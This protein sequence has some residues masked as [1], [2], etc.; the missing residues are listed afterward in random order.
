M[1][2]CVFALVFTLAALGL[3]SAHDVHAALSEGAPEQRRAL[4]AAESTPPPS[5]LHAALQSP[6]G[7]S[8]SA[9]LS[10]PPWWGRSSSAIIGMALV[11]LVAVG[12]ALRGARGTADA[13]VVEGDVVNAT[14][15][16]SA[17]VF[18]MI[19]PCLRSAGPRMRRHSRTL[20]R[21]PSEIQGTNPMDVVHAHSPH[22]SSAPRPTSPPVGAGTASWGGAPRSMRTPSPTHG[23]TPKPSPFSPGLGAPVA[24]AALERSVTPARAAPSPQHVAPAGALR[25]AGGI[26]GSPRSS[27]GALGL[28]QHYAGAAPPAIPRPQGAISGKEWMEMRMEMRRNAASSASP[29]GASSASSTS[30]ARAAHDA[31]AARLEHSRAT[32]AAAAAAAAPAAVR[33]KRIGDGRLRGALLQHAPGAYGTIVEALKDGLQPLQGGLQP[34]ATVVARHGGGA[35]ASNML[36]PP[37]LAPDTISTGASW[38]AHGGGHHHHHHAQQPHAPYT[39]QTAAPP[40]PPLPGDASDDEGAGRLK[41]AGVP[42]SSAQ[43]AGAVDTAAG[44]RQSLVITREAAVAVARGAPPPPPPP[45]IA[46]TVTLEAG[47]TSSTGTSRA[48]RMRQQQLQLHQSSSNASA[49]RAPTPQSPV[50]TAEPPA[51][52]E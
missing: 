23:D 6:T 15:G 20:R 30:A 28:H 12:G 32:A 49:G 50:A 38:A 35:G 25:A 16:P 36:P 44:A 1:T 18:D 19:C 17:S 47:S 7:T 46:P 51:P 31:A 48:E 24:A 52:G 2:R 10:V 40:P 39:R 22:P 37:A 5:A 9:I 8:S 4:R 21:S 43:A 27:V 14:S 34:R 11:V 26:S 29:P 3:A 42:R 13:T 45:P 33:V 41:S